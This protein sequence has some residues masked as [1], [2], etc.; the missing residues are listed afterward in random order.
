MKNVVGLLVRIR[1]NHKNELTEEE[2]KELNALIETLEK[3]LTSEE[4][5]EISDKQIS[6][7]H[8]RKV[9]KWLGIAG[10]VV[11]TALNYYFNDS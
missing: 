9:A 10:R 6:Q 4:Y 8:I 1:S 2:L 11:G 7:K 5:E 3:D